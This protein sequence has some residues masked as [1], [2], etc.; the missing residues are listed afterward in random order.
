MDEQ[1]LS[2]TDRNVVEP[3]REYAEKKR[4][5]DDRYTNVVVMALELADGTVIT[6]RS[7]RRF[8]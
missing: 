6:G 7:S 3:A 8:K 2:I 5:C 4:N 1:G